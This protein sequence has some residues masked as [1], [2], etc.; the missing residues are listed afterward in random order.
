LLVLTSIKITL[1]RQ[2]CFTLQSWNISF[3]YQSF[4]ILGNYGSSIIIHCVK[5]SGVATVQRN[6]KISGNWSPEK[7]IQF[8]LCYPNHWDSQENKTI[9]VVSD[10]RNLNA[11]LKNYLF[12]I[13]KIAGMI[14][15]MDS[16]TSGTALEFTIG[17]YHNKFQKLC[18]IVYPWQNNKCFPAPIGVKIATNVFQNVMSKLVQDTEYVTT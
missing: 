2:F 5:I 11:L 12:S 18:S 17:Y 7:I 16:L 10:F 6:F 14:G 13:P 3:L 9:K 8:W 1:C 4:I 15:A